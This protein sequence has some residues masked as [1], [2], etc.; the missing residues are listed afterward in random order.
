MAS[1]REEARSRLGQL[2]PSGLEAL[3]KSG[4]AA[5]AAGLGAG[6]QGGSQP[7]V[8][9][10]MGSDSDLATMKAAAQVCGG[11]E[12]CVGGEVW[13]TGVGETEVWCRRCGTGGLWWVVWQGRVRL[14]GKCW[15]GGRCGA[16]RF[17]RMQGHGRCMS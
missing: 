6:G 11:G 12:W 17:H 14:A 4:A 10:I 1:S 8:G 7:K 2:D 5:A 15:E 3:R 13:G 9:I 16:E